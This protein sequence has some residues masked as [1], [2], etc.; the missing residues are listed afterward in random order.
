MQSCKSKWFFC[1]FIMAKHIT[2]GPDG[3]LLLGTMWRA[4]SLSCSCVI[5]R[6]C[7]YRLQVPVPAS[8]RYLLPENAETV[9]HSNGAL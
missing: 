6:S 9:G 3:L 7:L 2:K 8:Y 4:H 5:F 1:A